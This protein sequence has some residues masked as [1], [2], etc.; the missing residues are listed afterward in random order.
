MYMAYTTNP[1]LPKLRMQAVLLVRKGW[2]IRAVARY[3]GYTPGAICKWVKRA[4][5]DGRLTIPTQSSRPHHHPS[6]LAQPIIE[7]IRIERLKHRRCAEVVHRTLENQGTIVSLSSVK[8]TLKR[9]GLIRTRSPWKVWHQSSPRPEATNPGDLE[10]MDT[11]HIQPSDGKRFYIYT[12][13]DLSSRWVHAKVVE[14]INAVQSVRFFREAQ[15]RAPFSFRVVQTDHG[16]E[17]ST[18]LTRR[19]MTMATVHRHSRVRQ[20]NDNGHVE[21]FNRTVQEECFTKLPPVLSLYR[22]ALKPYLPYYNGERLHLG[23]N[24]TTPLTKCFQ[25]ID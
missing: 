13:I 3:T 11:I 25:A 5:A 1:H 21:R 8:R 16:P 18:H 17:F 9:E 6:S 10:Q 22:K 2:S 20:A 12:L 15:Q 24:L 23:L 19:L 4:P 14:R 7:A